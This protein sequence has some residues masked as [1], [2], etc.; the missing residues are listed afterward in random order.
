[1]G[2]DPPVRREKLTGSPIRRVWRVHFR[3]WTCA[4]MRN[5]GSFTV[6]VATITAL[7]S[8]FIVDFFSYDFKSFH[9]LKHSPLTQ[10]TVSI[11]QLSLLQISEGVTS[12]DHKKTN[13][14]LLLFYGSNRQCS[15]QVVRTMRRRKLLDCHDTLISYCHVPK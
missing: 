12:F 15:R 3:K 6:S 5:T 4:R 1:M 11:L 2:G 9:P 13:N 10:T 7:H 8:V 14:A